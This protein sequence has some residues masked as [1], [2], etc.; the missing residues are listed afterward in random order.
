M[1]G[2]KMNDTFFRKVRDNH[3]RKPRQNNP[4]WFQNRRRR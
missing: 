2:F 1:Q 4:F 3:A